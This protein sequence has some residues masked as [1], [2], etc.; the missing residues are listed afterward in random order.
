MSLSST[1]TPHQVTLAKGIGEWPS[2]IEN[3]V[4]LGQTARA[5]TMSLSSSHYK[6]LIETPAAVVEANVER[7][8]TRRREAFCQLF[9]TRQRSR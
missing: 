2:H 9:V 3:E 5:G 4:L 6:H 8:Q 1:K 7:R